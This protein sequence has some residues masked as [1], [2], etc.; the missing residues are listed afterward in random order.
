MY[1]PK[2]MPTASPNCTIY[3][4]QIAVIATLEK[5][6]SILKATKIISECLISLGDKYCGT[7]LTKYDKTKQ[8]APAF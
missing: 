6:V 3:A 2:T 8:Q 4:Q 5:N 1:T 7:Q